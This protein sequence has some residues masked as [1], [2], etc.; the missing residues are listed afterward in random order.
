MTKAEKASA[1]RHAV[2]R[3]HGDQRHRDTLAAVIAMED[4]QLAELFDRIAE[5]SKAAA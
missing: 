5:Q 4:F 3:L 2:V 1:V